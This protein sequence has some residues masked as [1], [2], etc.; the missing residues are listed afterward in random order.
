VNEEL[1][2]LLREFVTVASEQE[3]AL[4]KQQIVSARISQLRPELGTYVVADGLAVSIA[5]D[6]CGYPT[7]RLLRTYNVD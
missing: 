1:K 5:G 2:H 6:I 7:C 4:T 3:R